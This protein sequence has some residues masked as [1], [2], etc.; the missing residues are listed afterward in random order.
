MLRK[1]LV[2]LLL[3]GLAISSAQADTVAQ[4]NFNSNPVDTST[5]TG[6]LL[7]SIGSGTAGTIGGVS[8]AFASGTSNGGSSDT[9]ATD[10]SGWQTTGYSLQ[11]AANKNAGVEFKVSTLGFQN[12]VIGYDLRHSNTSSRY[13]QV[14]YSLDGITFT[15]I[16]GFDGNAGD[17]WFN[18]RSVD[19]S[20]ILG[21]N[22]N[23]SFAFRVVSAF[24]P[25]S[26]AYLASAA[27]KSYGTAG[28]WRFDMVTVSAMPVPEPG[29]YAL[30]LAGIGLMGTV[31]RRR[32]RG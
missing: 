17:T 24:A 30:F 28:T 6:S 9:A 25:G 22:N 14:Q 26:A 29:S 13:E 1:S 2:T 27:D 23:A 7:P 10:D 8:S 18:G 12:I 4:W 3:A 19:L 21:A 32:S 11:G 5:S 15:D 31:A 16:A 20:S